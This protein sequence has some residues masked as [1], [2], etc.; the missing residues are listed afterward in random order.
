MKLNRTDLDKGLSKK[1]FDID[2]DQFHSDELNFYENTIKCEL[3]VE[4]SSNSHHISGAIKIPFEH[5]CDRC[6]IDFHE[7]RTIDFNFILT[8]NDELFQDTSDD[9]L[10]FSPNDD[11]IDLNPF[12]REIILLEI[13]LKR[14]CKEDCKGLCSNCG[15]NLNDDKCNCLFDIKDSPWDTLKKI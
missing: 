11:E 12:F 6:L 2:T 14:I 1:L 8:D 15:T 5:N 10:R 9:V 3:S 7:L 13:Q 4:R